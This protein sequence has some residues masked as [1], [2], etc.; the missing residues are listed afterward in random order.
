MQSVT[1]FHIVISLCQRDIHL[2]KMKKT[3]TD[4]IYVK[5]FIGRTSFDLRPKFTFQK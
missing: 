5:I 2:K 1:A 3:A 4:I